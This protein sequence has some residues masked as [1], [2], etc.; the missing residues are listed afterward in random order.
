M[1]LFY[2]LICYKNTLTKSCLF[3]EDVPSHNLGPYTKLRS[4]L[5]NSYVRCV[6]STDCKENKLLII[7]LGL[8]HSSIYR[9]QIL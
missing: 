4:H 2:F 5:T 7:E 6:I 9:N 1:L 3:L 8:A